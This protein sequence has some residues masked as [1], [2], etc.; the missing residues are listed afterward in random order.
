[1]NDTAG[2]KKQFDSK[3]YRIYYLQGLAQIRLLGLIAVLLSLVLGLLVIKPV[4]TSY[5][6]TTTSGVVVPLA[7]LSQPTVT[8]KFLR[9]WVALTVRQSYQLSFNGYEQQLEAIKKNFTT[10]GYAGFMNS[11]ESQGLLDTIKQKQINMTAVVTGTPATLTS[12]ISQGRRTWRMQMP[13]LV[14]FQSASETTKMDYIITVNV[15]RV[16]ALDAPLGG[17]LISSIYAAKR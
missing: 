9:Q 3:N 17:V 13:I 14:E 5:F 12:F 6:A 7:D 1:M 10:A 2:K 4:N 11:L 16:A 8:D 15:S